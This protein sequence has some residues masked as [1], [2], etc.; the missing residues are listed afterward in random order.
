MP[1]RSSYASVVSGTASAPSQTYQQPARSGA[2]SHLLN[3]NND[4]PYDPSLQNSSGALRHDSRD[5][6]M[7]IQRNGGSYNSSSSWNRSG[8]LPNFSSGY[9][10][11]TNGYGYDGIGGYTDNFFIPSYLRGSKHVQR[12]EE[13]YR[14]KIAARKDT[15]S[16]QSSQPGSLSK[17][18]SSANLH[19]KTAPSH[20]GMTFDVIEKSPPLTDDGLAPLPSRWNNQDK[21]AALEVQADGQEVKFTGTRSSDRD[22][23]AS[24]IRTDY[25]IPPQCGIYYFEVEILTRKRE[26]YVRLKFLTHGIRLTWNI[27]LQYA[28]DFPRKESLYQDLLDGNPNRGLIM[29]MM[30]IHIV[31][32]ILESITDHHILQVI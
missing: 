4:Y 16:A 28:W 19:A 32:K 20:R 31:V 3:Q 5:I 2:F 14:A 6:D 10:A 1:R 25:P 13:A 9:L 22:H 27:E 24:S 15:P 29:V 17:S 21:N 26:E 12:L 7:E 8:R 23:E 11:L 30:G 18:S